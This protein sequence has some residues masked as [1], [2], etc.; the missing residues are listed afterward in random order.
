MY[1]KTHNERMYHLTPDQ[2]QFSVW[3][4]QRKPYETEADFGETQVVQYDVSS[5]LKSRIR[6]AANAWRDG[7]SSEQIATVHALFAEA[8]DAGWA[9]ADM[10]RASMFSAS[11]VRSTLKRI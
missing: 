8:R 5:T 3:T 11:S 6:E 4:H 7:R 2:K 9:A 1:G 10:A